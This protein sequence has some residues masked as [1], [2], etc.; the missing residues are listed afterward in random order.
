MLGSISCLWGE[1]YNNLT[2]YENQFNTKKVLGTYA[3]AHFLFS[4]TWT[5]FS[6]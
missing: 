6:V 2:Q 1:V 3:N 4:A 5:I